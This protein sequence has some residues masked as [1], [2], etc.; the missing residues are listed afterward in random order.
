MATNTENAQTIEDEKDLAA[1]AHVNIVYQP[2]PI[3]P[4]LEARVRR[5]LDWRLMPILT[6]IFLFAFID[7]ANVGNARVLG[8]GHDLH[9]DGTRFNIG[10][11]GFYVT[12]IVFEI[13]ANILCK[14]VGPKIWIPF[15]TFSFGTITMCMSTMQNYQGFLAARIIL[16]MFEAGMHSSRPYG[17]SRHTKQSFYQVSCRVSHILFRACRQSQ[18]NHLNQPLS[19]KCITVTADT[20]SSLALDFTPVS[21]P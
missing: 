4:E 13:P 1:I 11:S 2:D 21:H 8:M 20:S 10:L 15:L 17:R 12:Y 7:R 16:G 9:L 3:D 5:K 18:T 19:N 14:K 6:L